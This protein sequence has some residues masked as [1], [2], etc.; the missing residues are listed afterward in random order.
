MVTKNSD[1]TEMKQQQIISY[2]IKPKYKPLK[3]HSQID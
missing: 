3:I 2:I 1:K